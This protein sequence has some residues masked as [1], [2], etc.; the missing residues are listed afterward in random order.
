MRLFKQTKIDFMGKRSIWYSISVATLVLALVGLAFKGV[1]LGIDFLGGTEILVRFQSPVSINDVRS[2]MDKS[3]FSGCEIKS[4]GNLNDVLIRTPR[5]GEG[6]KIATEIQAGLKTGFPTNAFEV[7]KEDK[8]GPK[9]GAELRR[10][11]IYA[12][13]ATLLIIMIYVGFRFHFIYGFAG[14][15][16][17][18]HDT[19]VTLGFVVLFDG[20]STHLNLELSQNLMAAFLT[21]IGFSIN[22]T[23]IVF[24]RI[25]ENLKIHKSESLFTIMNKSINE[26]LSRTVITSGTVILVLIVLIIFGGEVNRGFAFTFLIGTITGTYSSI[27]VASAIVLDYTQYKA[28]KAKKA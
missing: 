8:I 16:A 19:L 13:I 2:A 21:L 24:D 10:N 1:T 26:T 4:F 9:I 22:D 12:V 20:L 23:V 18:F 14:V 28:K 6:A 7:L 5:Q 11:A 15:V 17:L 25:R 3:G 27:Y